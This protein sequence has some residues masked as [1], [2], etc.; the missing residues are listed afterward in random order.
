[1]KKYII[2]PI[3]GDKILSTEFVVNDYYKIKEK[4]KKI[5]NELHDL[6]VLLTHYQSQS[7]LLNVRRVKI[8]DVIKERIEKLENELKELQN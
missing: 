7:E 8:I 3:T 2:N 6:N 4:I 5:E 1:M